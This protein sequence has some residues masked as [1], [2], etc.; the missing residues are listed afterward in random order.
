MKRKVMIAAALSLGLGSLFADV[1]W[2]ED[3]SKGETMEANG[4]KASSAPTG[5]VVLKDGTMEFHCAKGN[6]FHYSK[7]LPAVR[8][9]E[10]SFELNLN[11]TKA[12]LFNNLS[13]RLGAYGM[14]VYANGGARSFMMHNSGNNTDKPIHPLWNDQ[15]KM[16]KLRFDMDA[17]TVQYFVDDMYNPVFEEKD[18]KF[19]PTVQSAPTLY[20]GNYGRAGD[21][22]VNCIRNLQVNDLGGV[23]AEAA[24]ETEKVVWKEDFSKGS[25]MEANGYKASSAPTG[26][27]ELNDGVMTFH[28]AKGKSFHYTKSLPQVRKGEISFD[29]NLNT[30]NTSQFNNLSIRVGAYGLLVYAN[31]GARSLM[32][33]NSGKNY[34]KAIHPVWA[35]QWKKIAIRFDADAK[36]V[37]YFVDDMTKP[38][39]EEKNVIFKSAYLQNPVISIGNYG[40]TGGTVVNCIRNLQVKDLD[41]GRRAAEEAKIVWKEDFSKG[42]TME[43][44]GYK[45][46]ADNGKDTIE[47]KDG[48][49]R[50]RC[51]T[52]PYKGSAY[53]KKMP[54]IRRG[55]LSFDIMMNAEKSTN[56]T[57]LSMTVSL[58]EALMI[59]P[60]GTNKFIQRYNPGTQRNNNLAK[61]NSGEWY[62]MAIRY[63]LD[64]RTAEYYVND[65]ENP[66]FVD[67]YFPFNMDQ[68][69]KSNLKIGNY[70]L[71]PGD[72]VNCLRN[73]QL[74]DLG[75]APD[76]GAVVWKEDFSKGSTMEANGYV[77]VGKNPADKF[78][79]KDNT[80]EMTCTKA[81][82]K[83]AHYAKKIPMLRKGELS[84]FLKVN[85]KKVSK[86]LYNQLSFQFFLYETL[87]LCPHGSPG[88]FQR[89]HPG[90][91]A[92]KAIA[93]LKDGMWH[94]IML[95]YD[96]D[97]KTVQYF[98]DDMSKPAFEEKDF[99]F[100]MEAAAKSRIR[101]GNYGLSNGTVTH[102]I[103]D[104]ELRTL[105][106]DTEVKKASDKDGMVI[107]RGMSADLYRLNDFAKIKK[108]GSVNNCNLATFAINEHVTNRFQYESM[109][110]LQGKKV[111]EMIILCDV[112]LGKYFTNQFI[113][114]LEDNV[115]RG[116]HLLI[117]GGYFTLNKGEMTYEKMKEMLPV[118]C[119][120]PFETLIFSSPVQV[121]NCPGATVRAVHKV[122]VR[123]G[124]EVKS[125]VGDHPFVVTKP[126]GFG[127]VTVVTGIPFGDVQDYAVSEDWT[128]SLCD[129]LKQTI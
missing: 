17:K 120:K 117:L 115:R 126:Y 52:S 53:I 119:G 81:P 90:N 44:N 101:I 63:D 5:K 27:V 84:F 70:G 129:M 45:K 32:M 80:M 100:N 102:Q 123:D 121:D 47:I 69:F 15:W 64:K 66:V 92:N 87:M 68:A 107:F 89:Y 16:I 105:K 98:V 58:Y 21:T 61:I 77:S 50:F 71:A 8:K 76:S 7:S 43:A 111:P 6:S 106:S 1:V 56:F 42:S 38:V 60:H 34:D 29:L 41:A 49:M 13:F 125:K 62:R 127:R 22:I 83:G 112:P 93:K 73:I 23:K 14:L 79:I 20:I 51:E 88:T 4:Y 122:Q 124:A 113:D 36:T 11:A 25:T 94:K 54:F 85:S 18:F 95:R 104:I 55:E 67:E 39:F 30:A 33:H 2:K 72:V 19:N 59:C 108:N 118:V 99:P 10:I 96:L 116:A 12:R 65:M 26:K 9:G 103:R 48:V 109:P 24:A 31:G 75:D 35:N 97:A 82:Y 3:F 28:C 37:Q 110:T 74:K 46:I 40:A 91:K 78:V 128:T 57:H 114:R 86:N